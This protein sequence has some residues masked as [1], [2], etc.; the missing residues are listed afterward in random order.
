MIPMKIVYMGT[1]EF[2]LPCLSS[3]IE[4][5]DVAAVFSQPDRPRGRGYKL[6]PTPVKKLALEHGIDV[7][8]PTSFKSGEDADKAYEILRQI[9]PDVI[10]VVA[11]G[12]ILPERVLE[13]PKYGCINVHASLLPKYRG[14]APIQW[15]VINGEKETG[16]T[17]MH[18]ARGL[19]TGDMILK[20]STQIGDNETATELHDRL[21]RMSAPLLLETLDLI[22][23]GTAPRESQNHDE[24][25]YAPQLSREMSVIDFTKPAQEVHNL[26][27]GLSEWPCAQITLCGKVMKIYKSELV[28][29]EFPDSQPGE[30]VNCKNF[31]VACGDKRAIRVMELQIRGSRRMCTQACLCGNKI[32]QGDII[33]SK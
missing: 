32:N 8:Q 4:N 17:T 3:L 7:F 2:A 1:P 9:A 15:S 23:Q 11:Y 19:D 21:S 29:E 28:N 31:T 24:H 14:A 12:A 30:I 25:T 18:M 13:L 22:E 20:K 6:M 33:P 10:V 27:R 26:I 5:H 16:I